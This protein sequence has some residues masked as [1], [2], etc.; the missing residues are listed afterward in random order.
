MRLN[1]RAW[2]FIT[3]LT[4]LSAFT[5][6]FGLY[7]PTLVII[8]LILAVAIFF[9]DPNRTPPNTGIVAPA[10]GRVSVLEED[11]DRVR[12]GIFL[13]IH[14]VH[15]VRSPTNTTA[16]DITH[17]PGGNL[18]AFYKNSGRNERL[19]FT[20]TNLTVEMIAGVLIRRTH[21]YIDTTD[22]VSQGQRIGHIDFGSRVDVLL[23][24]Q[25]SQHDLTVNKWD[26]VRAGE[27]IIAPDLPQ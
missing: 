14:N 19:E 15:V 21:S 2:D 1:D 22:T 4:V 17:H 7:A 6:V 24:E 26:R 27:T 23:P 13:N 18:P 11:G 10:D 8:T 9:R 25:Y 5:F 20:F 16:T 12:L 3:P